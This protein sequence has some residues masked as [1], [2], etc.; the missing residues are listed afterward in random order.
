MAR[1]PI[2]TLFASAIACLAALSCGPASA[3]GGDGWDI[4]YYD[5]GPYAG[6][7]RTAEQHHL[8]VGL[9]K[10][11]DPKW[12]RQWVWAEFDFILR[13]SP[14]HPIALDWMIKLCE[15]WKSPR[16]ALDDYLEKAVAI[17]PRVATTYVLRGIYQLRFD[18]PKLAVES[19]KTALELDPSSMNAHYNLGLAYFDLKEYARSNEHAQAAYALGAPLPGLREKLRAVGRWDPGARRTIDTPPHSGRIGATKPDQ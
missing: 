7:I 12:D 15:T 16:C 3:R 17:N 5:P 6:T 18:K 14:N 9:R 1:S 8:G 11:K 4:D 2:R 19:F 13:T 10:L